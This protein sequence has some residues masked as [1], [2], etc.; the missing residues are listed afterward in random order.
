MS[1][2][3]LGKVSS[4]TMGQSPPSET[5][6]S[7]KIG[8][9]FFQGKS[10]F[11]IMY[12]SVRI[13]CDQ[14]Q[15]V[16]E[17]GD[18]LISVRAPVG[19][20]NIANQKCC[21]G[22]GLAAISALPKIT[23]NKYIF[24]YLRYCEKKIESM[25]V[26]STFKAISKKDL[27][28]IQIPIPPLPIQQK[29]AC[30]FDLIDFLIAKRRKQI[31]LLDLLVKAQFVGMFGDPVTNPMRWE[32]GT[33]R[34]IVDEVKYGTSKPANEGGKYPYLRMNNITYDGQLNLTDLKYI[35][36]QDNEF[37]KYIVRKN[38]VLFNRTNS[39]EL[40]GKTCVFNVDELMVIA[41]Y[42]I[43]IR[44]NEKAL[45]IYLSS[46]LNSDYGK[47]T[48]RGMCKTI[49]GQSNINAQELQ[50]IQI[51]IPPLSLQTRF[52]DFVKQVDKSKFVLQKGLEKL[53]LAYKALMQQYFG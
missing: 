6:N 28:T 21:I 29:I 36:I 50:N 5:Y 41:G 7:E 12:P 16:A 27:E 47:L 43:R 25:G 39:K 8:L 46:V 11:G 22:R 13:H 45:P 34:D 52:A 1:K 18:I 2:W 17:A 37:E 33:I 19:S 49:I 15:K 31:E 14:P 3:D 30:L 4:I 51:L 40:V 42:I 24:Y 38:D 9:P 20:T 32:C 26:G 35:D 53:E 48:L 23:H 10:D 44:L